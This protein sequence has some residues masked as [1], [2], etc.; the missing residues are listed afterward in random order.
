MSIVH[1]ILWK[2]LIHCTKKKG[3]HKNFADVTTKKIQGILW[4]SFFSILKSIALKEDRK[5]ATQIKSTSKYMSQLVNLLPL[6]RVEMYWT[7]I[8]LDE[9]RPLFF[10]FENPQ[11]WDTIFLYDFLE[12]C[13]IIIH[14]EKTPKWAERKK[15]WMM[16]YFLFFFIFW[17]KVFL[18]PTHCQI[19][20]WNMH[21][22]EKWNL[23]KKKN[24]PKI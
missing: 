19:N 11:F 12:N 9:N 22:K 17:I 5:S 24:S 23:V 13:H 6:R 15:K 16:Y 3:V 10:L 18:L 21:Q 2:T 4:F 8:Y 1:G 14:F 7:I 20:K